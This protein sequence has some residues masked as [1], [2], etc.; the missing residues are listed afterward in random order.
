MHGQS[1]YCVASVTDRLLNLE[2]NQ[3]LLNA[4]Y[5]KLRRLL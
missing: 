1:N 4:I 3:V 5:L 2:A